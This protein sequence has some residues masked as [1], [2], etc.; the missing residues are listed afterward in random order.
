MNITKIIQALPTFLRRHKLI[1]FLLFLSP[2]SQTQLV[3]FNDNASAYA[4]VSDPFIQTIL[5]TK[6]FEPEFFSIAAPFL[7]KGGVFLILEQT[8]DFAVLA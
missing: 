8:M 2:Q 7:S 4:N 5:I 3:Q 6:S 1:N